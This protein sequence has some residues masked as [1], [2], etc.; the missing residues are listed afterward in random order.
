MLELGQ[1]R[2]V[3]SS[4]LWLCDCHSRVSVTRDVLDG[5]S[6]GLI[7]DARNVHYRHTFS[8]LSTAVLR[9]LCALGRTS[10]IHPAYEVYMMRQTK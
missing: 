8:D 3:L 6:M 1:V 9:R 10:Q 5:N 2:R 7:L 4:S